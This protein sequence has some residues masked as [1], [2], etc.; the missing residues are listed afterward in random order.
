[1]VRIYTYKINLKLFFYN[2]SY[3]YGYFNRFVLNKDKK[4]QKWDFYKVVKIQLNFN[5]LIFSAL[6]DII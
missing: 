2:I 6:Q 1:M 5:K 4:F 3:E